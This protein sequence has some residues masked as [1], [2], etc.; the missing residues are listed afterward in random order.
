MPTH[1]FASESHLLAAFASQSFTLSVFPS[2]P[3]ARKVNMSSVVF[4]AGQTLESRRMTLAL[5]TSASESESSR[6]YLCSCAYVT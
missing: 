6:P 3:L 2:L 4:I 5:N 1:V